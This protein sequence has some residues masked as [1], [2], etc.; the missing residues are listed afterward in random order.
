MLHGGHV[1]CWRLLYGLSVSPHFASWATLI[2]PQAEVR[3]VGIGSN[4]TAQMPPLLQEGSQV[5]QVMI[6]ALNASGA[7]RARSLLL[8][9]H[10]HLRR[11]NLGVV[12]A[13]GPQAWS[14]P[15]VSSL[16]ANQASLEESNAQ[17]SLASTYWKRNKVHQSESQGF[18]RLR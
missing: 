10:L 17:S 3:P 16:S 2:P 13:I 12:E 4:L 18:L 14:K 7:M 5:A 6:S 15:R 1:A 11:G 8:A 9:P